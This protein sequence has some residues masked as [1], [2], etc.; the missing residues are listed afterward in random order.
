MKIGNF[1]I[2]LGLFSQL[3]CKTTSHSHVK[4]K[5]AT[6]KVL[7]VGD[8]ITWG[9]VA[10]EDETVA[11]Q[12]GYGY[13]LKNGLELDVE[14]AGCP[15]ATSRDFITAPNI[16]CGGTNKETIFQKTVLPKIGN[17]PIDVMTLMLGTND[18]T[19]FGEDDGPIKPENYKSNIKKILELAEAKGISKFI[20]MAPPPIPSNCEHSAD[21][22]PRI[23]K[24]ASKLKEICNNKDNV[25]CLMDNQSNMD[26]SH[27]LDTCN[28]HPNTACAAQIAKNLG[29]VIN[30]S[31]QTSS[32]S[33]QNSVPETENSDVCMPK[34]PYKDGWMGA[35]AAVSILLDEKSKRTIWLFGDT[36]IQNNG[37]ESREAAQMPSLTAALSTCSNG[38]FNLEGYYWDNDGRVES[39]IKPTGISEDTY[40]PGDG[41][42]EGGMLF[43]FLH[44][45]KKNGATFEDKGVDLAIIDNPEESPNNWNIRVKEIR[46]ESDFII[47]KAAFTQDNFA[48][49]AG[50]FPTTED[51]KD[52]PIF[53]TRAKTN[54]LFSMKDNLEYLNK[55]KKWVK[56]NGDEKRE[57]FHFILDKGMAEF[58]LKPKGDGGFRMVINTHFYP[59]P[60]I[61][62][63]DS[64]E[65]AG[66]YT[67]IKTYEIPEYQELD[68]S[69]QVYC[70][71]GRQ[72]PQFT[73]G[74]EEQILITYVCNSFDFLG[75]TVRENGIYVP[76]GVL[77]D[78]E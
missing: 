12:L 72:H 6:P 30:S 66:S 22:N 73:K 49:I 65:I 64:D 53:I 47:G 25:T 10:G 61:E 44:R 1:L 13:I 77:L 36:F 68:K 42:V 5:E 41:F 24:Y 78:L 52:M 14:V 59:S 37:T 8:S 67:K 11:S 70:Y 27:Y 62:V 33:D 26:D 23:K 7:I 19:G 28:V 17:T 40:W 74:G 18:S 29:A 55:N 2:Y 4:Y 56:L 69:L 39:F 75:V 31:L 21:T 71:A 76:Q 15:G 43:I 3:A 16:A 38:E 58:S 54:Q 46:G 45:I 35:D 48:Y 32:A 51:D 57:D 60:S 63:Y 20:L 50:Y 34:F 9:Q